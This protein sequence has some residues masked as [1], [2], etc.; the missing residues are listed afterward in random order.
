MTSIMLAS[1]WLVP[2]YP[3]PVSFSALDRTNTAHCAQRPAKGETLPRVIFES[4]HS[5][6]QHR[7]RS[8]SKIESLCLGAAPVALAASRRNYLQRHVNCL[9]FASPWYQKLRSVTRKFFTCL[10]HSG[11]WPNVVLLLPCQ[12]S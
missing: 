11:L 1:T 6:S 5:S 10:C 8:W 12:I 4:G 9:P 2:F 3:K 7:R